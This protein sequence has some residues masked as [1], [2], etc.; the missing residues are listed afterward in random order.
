LRSLVRL[1]RAGR[2]DLVHCHAAK[3]GALGRVA[4]RL[5]GVP[6]IYSPHC[7]P[8]VGDLSSR[9]RAVSLGLER[10]LAPLTTAMLCVCEH[11]RDL[12]LRHGLAR[13]GTAHV[14]LNGCDPCAATDPDGRLVALRGD[15][16]LAGAVSV[17]REQKGLHD[18]IAAAPRVLAA[19]PAARIAIVGDGPKRPA[20]VAHA[21]ALGLEAEPRFALLAYEGPAERHLRALDVY[22][23]PS[24]WEALPIGPLQAMACGVAQ[25]ATS[26]GGTPEAV[27]DRTGVLVAPH[28]PSA[29]AEALVRLL[30]DPARRRKLA[31]SSPA[32]HAERFT[33][34]R[35]VAE[36]AQVYRDVVASAAASTAGARRAS[37]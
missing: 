12:A 29:L 16:V 34:G 19:L 13:R 8:F 5:A 15:G 25:V 7:L 28:D 21:A 36:T 4:A 33:V 23:L 30:S 3:A 24:L 20:L 22:V 27:T 14:V 11:E 26:V 9:R 37:A 31:D 1:L 35:M 17:L 2:F 6:A 18:L 10:L 32:V